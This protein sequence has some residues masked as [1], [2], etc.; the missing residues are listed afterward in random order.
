MQ[1]PAISVVVP[2]R[3]N[4]RLGHLEERLRDLIESRSQHP[5]VEWLLA[6][7]SSS[8]VN[9]IELEHF[10][11]EH[12]VRYVTEP[13][14]QFF[15]LGKIRNFGASHA[16]GDLLCFYDIDL[17]VE[18]DFWQRLLTLCNDPHVFCTQRTVISI[19]CLYLTEIGTDEYRPIKSITSWLISEGKD[20]NRR[21]CKLLAPCSSFI[22]LNRLH[23]LSLGGYDERYCGHSFEDFELLHR[24]LRIEGRYSDPPDYYEDSTSWNPENNFGFRTKFLQVGSYALEQNLIALHLWHEH[25]KYDA[26]YQSRG[27]NRELLSNSMRE[28]DEAGRHPNAPIASIPATGGRKFLFLGQEGSHSYQTLMGAM[29]LVGAVHMQSEYDFFDPVANRLKVDGL[30]SYLE[31]A[32][33]E[34][35]LFPNPHRNPARR[36]LFQWCRKEDF[37]YLVFERGGLPD[38][39]FFDS[40][41]FNSDSRSYDPSLWDRILTTTQKDNVRKYIRETLKG[42]KTLEPQGERVGMDL[43]RQKLAIPESKKILFVP[44]QRPSDT[45][46]TQF[47]G[48]AGSFDEFTKFI[49]RLADRLSSDDWV[50]VCKRH[51][52]EAENPV[53]PNARFADPSD[54]I[55]DLVVLSDAIAVMNSGVGLYA[56]MAG[57]P[58]YAFSDSYYGHHG[59][60]QC[61]SELDVNAFAGMLARPF[62]PDS[63]RAERFVHYLAFEFYSFG[64]ATYTDW[65]AE[66]GA[67]RKAATAID[68]R[69]V[70]I[71]QH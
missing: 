6:D 35:M 17:R 66:D 1:T 18:E 41:G 12:A 11:Q 44:L 63:A 53:I 40:F 28:F 54:H 16:T 15:S 64:A 65:I 30:R 58:C 55:C 31:S 47:A 52:Y 37:P 51:P 46:T 10:C 56:I 20:H 71:P 2:F 23:F 60:V 62:S 69:T 68:F 33:I 49:N 67:T 59:L 70:R 27:K 50:V 26:F 32:K 45:V 9:G 4:E 38:S 14:E 61:P 39:W 5:Q 24:L 22:I 34:L 7:A 29:P 25:P 36:A 19:P 57:K 8:D 48:V 43:L 21:L 13:Q 3:K 42:D